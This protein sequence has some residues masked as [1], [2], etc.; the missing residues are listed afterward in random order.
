MPSRHLNSSMNRLVLRMSWRKSSSIRCR[1]SRSRRMVSVRR[2]LMVG[3]CASST[4]TSSRAN[5]VRLKT[6]GWVTSR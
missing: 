2:P 6:F 5:G 4:K 1:L 3:F